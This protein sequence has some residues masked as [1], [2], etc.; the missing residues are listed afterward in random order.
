MFPQKDSSSGASYFVAG[1]T[2]IVVLAGMG[3]VICIYGKRIQP[4]ATHKTFPVRMPAAQLVNTPAIQPMEP[5]RAK[6]TAHAALPTQHTSPKTGAAVASDAAY[7]RILREAASEELG[8]ASVPSHKNAAS[9]PQP[10]PPPPLPPPTVNSGIMTYD[11]PPSMLVGV[12]VPIDVVV[13]WPATPAEAVAPNAQQAAGLGLQTQEPLQSK[14][15]PVSGEMRVT[16]RSE[17]PGAFSITPTETDAPNI[18]HILQPGGHSEW[19]WTVTANQP[20]EHHL[21]LHSEFIVQLPDG[22]SGEID[23]GTTE[24]TIQIQVLP[25]PVRTG[26]FLR[27]IAQNNWKA[28]LGFLLPSGSL[29][30]IYAARKKKKRNGNMNK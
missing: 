25:W 13:Q 5:L 22:S 29:Y 6:H 14:T 12:S 7:L 11:P 9:P 16:L 19:H 2:A 28:I 26:K 1:G 18:L 17:E 24:T 8:V 30:S 27:N 10:P 23:Q 20:G 4:P 21:L 15:I 3:M